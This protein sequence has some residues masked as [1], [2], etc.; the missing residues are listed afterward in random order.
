MGT[1]KRERQ[2]ANRQQRLQQLAQQARVRKTKR[3]GLRV[4]GIIAAVVVIVGLVAWLGD[5]ETETS[6]STVPSID[7]T[8]TTVPTPVPKPSVE[9][10]AAVPTELEVTTLIEGSGPAAAAGDTVRVLYVGVRSAD[11][12]EFDNNYDSGR[13]FPVELGTGSVI[14]GWDQ[15]LIGTQAGGRYQ[16]DIPAELAY[17][18]Q[19]RGDVIR[20]GDALTFI[21]DVLEV[22]PAS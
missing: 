7:V 17:G 11:G 12:V 18:D 15:G 3:V 19:Q 9:L 16:L 13:A 4:G 6:A 2:K 14:D 22:T 21:V 5:D 8:D 1:T 20:P 10:P